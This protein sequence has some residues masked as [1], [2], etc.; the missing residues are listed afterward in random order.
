MLE[1]FP[2]MK[3]L[4]KDDG[5]AG[6]AKAAQSTIWGCTSPELLDGSVT[7][8]Y[9]GQDTTELPHHARAADPE[10]QARIVAAIEAAE[11]K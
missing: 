10:V 8:K 7:G 11:N 2:C 4:F 3:C 6:A 1:Q 5:G 9:F